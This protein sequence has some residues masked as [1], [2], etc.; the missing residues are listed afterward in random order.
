MEW[1]STFAELKQ[2]PPGRP[3]SVRSP[4]NIA[5]VRQAFVRSPQRSARKHAAALQL[6]DRS[7]RRILQQDL[8]PGLLILFW[9]HYCSLGESDTEHSTK[10]AGGS[11]MGTDK[12]YPHDWAQLIRQ[13]ARNKP[14]IVRDMQR[15]EFVDFASLLKV[16][17]RLQQR[18]GIEHHGTEVIAFVDDLL[19][20]TKGKNALDA[21]NFANQDIKKIEEW[22]KESKIQ[23]NDAKSKVLLIRRKKNI[24]NEMVNIY[25]NNKPLEQVAELKYLGM[26]ID[27]NFRFDY[28]I[29]Q[30]HNRAINLIH[31][32]SKAAKL[33][34][35][36]GNKAL[37]TIYR[38]AIEPI[39]TYGAPV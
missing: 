19:I 4:Q 14:C 38:G 27:K 34:W 2:K 33:T 28:H 31:A 23:F 1:S 26:W 39:L 32:L 17:L 36:L 15:N 24:R 5:I 3:R 12:E 13:G 21:E 37:H 7:L 20:M 22:V 18:W 10:N 30:I 16:P 29:D 35:G 25:L 6:S 11:S 9:S 8:N